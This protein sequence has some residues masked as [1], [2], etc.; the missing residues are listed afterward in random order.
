[1]LLGSAWDGYVFGRSAYAGEP[2][3]ALLFQSRAQAREWCK[4][5]RAQY[6]GRSDVCAQWRFKPVRVREM[7]RKI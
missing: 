2:P 7:V 4:K 6:S 5:K 1:M 3:M